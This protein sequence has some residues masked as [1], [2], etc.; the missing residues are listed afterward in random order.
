MFNS[1]LPKYKILLILIFFGRLAKNQF[2]LILN[3]Y[4][5]SNDNYKQI[6]SQFLNFKTKIQ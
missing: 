6:F 1:I 5:N 2:K 3:K 4:F